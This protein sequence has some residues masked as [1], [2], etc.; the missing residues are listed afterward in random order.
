MTQT[1]QPKTASKSGSHTPGPDERGNYWMDCGCMVNRMV[2]TRC[3]LHAKAPEMYEMLS[4]L[5]KAITKEDEH[6]S[7]PLCYNCVRVL[8]KSISEA[9]RIKAEID[10]E[11]KRGEG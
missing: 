6:G 10:R 1:K 9:H 2:T 8:S 5:L 7:T 3:N 11:A 4:G